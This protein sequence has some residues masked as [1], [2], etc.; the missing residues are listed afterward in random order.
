MEL[1]LKNN[2]HMKNITLLLVVLIFFSCT[3]SKIT[4]NYQELSSPNKVNF[5][6]DS[7]RKYTITDMDTST[8]KFNNIIY[9]KRND[10]VYKIVTKKEIV[11]PCERLLIS[12]KYNLKLRSTRPK[13]LLNYLDVH[14]RVM[15][16]KEVIYFERG[17]G[18]LWD[19]YI[20][21]YIK[22][23]CYQKD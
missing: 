14:A 16:K 11:K 1:S 15:Y 8:Y 2:N 6:N 7:L 5:I 21:P 23:L 4:A 20:T 17:S 13:M 18:I 3:S 22:D 10:T 12:N 9:A 19:L